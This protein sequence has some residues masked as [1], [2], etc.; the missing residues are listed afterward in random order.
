MDNSEWERL[1][2][3][4][5][6]EVWRQHQAQAGPPP[7]YQPGPPHPPYQQQPAGPSNERAAAQT[8]PRRPFYKKKRFI[9]PLVLVVLLIVLIATSGNGGNGAI[10]PAAAPSAAATPPAP[11]KAITARD[12][13]LIAKD[14]GSHQG[15]SII[16]YGEISQFDSATGP[17]GLL[18][19]VD[20]VEHQLQSGFADYS[21]NTVMTGDQAALKDV[22]QKD[23]FKASVT[24]TGSRS[25]DTQIGGKTTAPELQ[26]Q[27]IQ[28]IG[29]AN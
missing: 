24:V 4:Q 20:G 25:Y 29:H 7:G 6:A 10:T 17:T 13:Q 22:V 18:A 27:S 1:S 21:T 8:K 3:E 2:P 19:R 16:V 5:K 14:P 15:E 26:I 28:V 9:I 23:V 12:W 11:A